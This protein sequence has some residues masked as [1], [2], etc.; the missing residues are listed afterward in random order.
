VPASELGWT[1][2]DYQFDAFSL[3][4]GGQTAGHVVTMVPTPR[5]VTSGV[6]GLIIVGGVSRFMRRRLAG[7]LN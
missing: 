1:G 2:H 6:A 4:D 3:V 5:A 7:K